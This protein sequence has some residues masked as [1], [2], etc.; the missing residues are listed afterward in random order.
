MAP[1]AGRLR[2]R[3]ASSSG[4]GA[5]RSLQASSHPI[6][7]GRNRTQSASSWGQHA[8]AKASWPKK[9]HTEAAA[10][11]ATASTSA[12]RRESGV[13]AAS[14]TR[15][16][17][18]PP[19]STVVSLRRN[20]AASRSA[21]DAA[22]TGR[23]SADFGYP[24]RQWGSDVR[25]QNQ[26]TE[27]LRRARTHG[28]SRDE[29]SSARSRTPLRGRFP[30]KRATLPPPPS[31]PQTEGAS[32]AFGGKSQ[33][34]TSGL[35][36]AVSAATAGSSGRGG[37]GGRFAARRAD[38]SSEGG[39]SARDRQSTKSIGPIAPIRRFSKG[40]PRALRQ[41]AASWGGGGDATRADG[42]VNQSSTGVLVAR[43]AKQTRTSEDK[44]TNALIGN[45]R[46]QVFGNDATAASQQR[47][48]RL[49]AAVSTSRQSSPNVGATVAVSSSSS[50]SSNLVAPPWQQLRRGRFTMA[51]AKANAG[52]RKR[53]QSTRGNAGSAPTATDDVQ[54]GGTSGRAG[55]GGDGDKVVGTLGARG[56]GRAVFAGALASEALAARARCEAIARRGHLRDRTVFF[57]NMPTE[58]SEREARHF[59]TKAGCVERI[60]L[61]HS[62][63]GGLCEFRDASSA[64][65]AV[66]R[67]NG[68]HQGAAGQR[69]QVRFQ[70]QS[71]GHQS[72]WDTGTEA[73]SNPHYQ[74]NR[75]TGRVAASGDRS[76]GPSARSLRKQR[77]QRWRDFRDPVR[78][79]LVN[80]VADDGKDDAERKRER[81]RAARNENSTAEEQTGGQPA[82][83]G[84]GDDT[85]EDANLRVGRR[86]TISEASTA[87]EK[88][89]LSSMAAKKPRRTRC[90]SGLSDGE[91]EKK[92]S[93][94]VFFQCAKLRYR[95]RGAL[96]RHLLRQGAVN[97]FAWIRGRGC[98][99]TGYG[100]CHY[101]S[102][103]AARRALAE[104]SWFRCLPGLPG[105]LQVWRCASTARS[106]GFGVTTTADSSP[107]PKRSREGDRSCGSVRLLP[108]SPT[109][110]GRHA[111]IKE[112]RDDGRSQ[113][114]SSAGSHSN[115]SPLVRRKRSSP[116]PPSR[117]SR[118]PSS[119]A[120]FSS[121][122][123]DHD[124]SEAPSPSPPRDNRKV[125]FKGI[126]ASEK[127]CP[128]PAKSATIGV[129]LTPAPAASAVSTSKQNDRQSCDR[130]GSAA[131]A[132]DGA[133]SA[134][135][136]AAA[137]PVTSGNS[138]TGDSAAQGNVEP[139]VGGCDKSAR[140]GGGDGAADGSSVASTDV[141]VEATEESAVTS[142]VLPQKEERSSTD[143]DGSSTPVTLAKP[144][145][146]ASAERAPVSTTPV[147]SI[148]QAASKMPPE[149]TAAVKKTEMKKE[150]PDPASASTSSSVSASAKQPSATSTA[151][152]QRCDIIGVR[153][154]LSGRSKTVRHSMS[155]TVS[156]I[157]TQYQ[158]QRACGQ[159]VAK[160][161][162]GF[163]IG[164]EVTLGQM[165]RGNGG[166]GTASIPTGVLEI[167]L[168]PDP[169]AS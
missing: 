91:E 101:A 149:A 89:A 93:R 18:P 99:F 72:S 138:T 63:R 157:I 135:P 16:F 158:A 104:S 40:F 151:E 7:W 75:G 108:R 51:A 139:I 60:R 100:F 125:E 32:G 84:T 141:K 156:Q 57:V 137:S 161:S 107:L 29:G 46:R 134:K 117:R 97:G 71:S 90:Q 76:K 83:D 21:N 67:L 118:S 59:F 120:C 82:V 142:T 49:V 22:G 74:H 165:L 68:E 30:V 19:R 119:G 27:P 50:S 86:R 36:T 54:D 48:R 169:W 8:E 31:P 37:G 69:I 98:R 56:R 80:S 2:P 121:D 103:T 143:G 61:F 10:D 58:W 14:D 55:V 39:I 23:A 114:G 1:D 102:V 105:P 65:R 35:S 112:E 111:A 94:T 148:A 145:M 33:P 77:W 115:R 45:R 168:E 20:S 132:H 123:S 133:K 127:A 167:T 87:S 109:L 66:K 166:G 95:S 42:K 160:D 85:T 122:G 128:K 3:Q 110:G 4:G 130:R 11:D 126:V 116:G 5:S 129:V 70:A 140:G 47:H 150:Q 162:A 64:A 144:V 26:D 34:A 163:E 153:I 78:R 106:L 146:A 9:W 136:K 43:G 147:S 164:P 113:A 81:E 92:E 28:G 154:T 12:P 73:S 96:R 25:A 131:N 62:G 17:C 52:R 15:S 152:S 24:P 44:G 6:R 53:I 13:G 79:G 124:A 41:R 38:A 159:L 155:T 88:T